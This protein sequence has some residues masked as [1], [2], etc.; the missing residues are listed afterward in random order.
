MNSSVVAWRTAKL[1]RM[2]SPGKRATTTANHLA[3]DSSDALTSRRASSSTSSATPNINNETSLC[4]QKVRGF[5]T[6]HA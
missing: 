4:F 3:P 2:S 5:P 6:P 1:W